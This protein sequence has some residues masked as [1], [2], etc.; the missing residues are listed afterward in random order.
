MRC[1]GFSPRKH[2]ADRSL[3]TNL[4]LVT[5]WGIADGPCR[6]LP[7]SSFVNAGIAGRTAGGRVPAVRQ[8]VAEFAGRP[9]PDRGRSRETGGV[10]DGG[11]GR[12]LFAGCRRRRPRRSGCRTPARGRGGS[13]GSVLWTPAAEIGHETKRTPYL[14]DRVR[15]SVSGR[16]QNGAPSRRAESCHFTP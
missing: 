8:V 11:R 1:R 10:P 6:T 3:F 12:R 9:D 5:P 16:D 7:A 2:S 15:C 13:G 14:G 4:D